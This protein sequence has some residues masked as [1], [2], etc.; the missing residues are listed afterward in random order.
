MFL[1]PI[2]SLQIRASERQVAGLAEAYPQVTPARMIMARRPRWRG[3]RPIFCRFFRKTAAGVKRERAIGSISN[4]R[5][6]VIAVAIRWR[7]NRH[8]VRIARGGAGPQVMSG[9][10][11]ARAATHFAMKRWE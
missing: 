3:R 10:P 1:R 5:L 4:W 7:S 8:V 9:K 2:S 11:D 6:R